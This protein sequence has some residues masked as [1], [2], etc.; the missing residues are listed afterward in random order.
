MKIPIKR[1][2]NKNLSKYLNEDL[3][4]ARKFAKSM[5]QEFGKFISS[6]V[7]FGSAAKHVSNPK[8]DID[9]LPQHS[10]IPYDIKNSQLNICLIFF[11]VKLSNG[12]P[13]HD[14]ILKLYLYLFINGF[15]IIILPT[16]DAMLLIVILYLLKYFIVS[17][18][19]YLF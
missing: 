12:D 5:H 13:P 2:E 18:I 6:M 8:R 17:S 3:Q 16:V 4:I 9:I 14:K 7:L 1:K 10:V 19:L 15:I 11:T